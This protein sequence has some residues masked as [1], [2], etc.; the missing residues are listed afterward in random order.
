MDPEIF[1]PPL[2]FTL[3]NAAAHYNTNPSKEEQDMMKIF[4]ISLPGLIPCLK[5]N[6]HTMKYLQTSDLNKAVK[7]KNNLIKFM[8]DFHN[9]VNQRLNKPLWT[10]KQVLE[11]YQ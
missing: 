4:L 8:L 7:N 5:C 1:G 9:S 6:Q 2:W 3:H 11:K 10:L